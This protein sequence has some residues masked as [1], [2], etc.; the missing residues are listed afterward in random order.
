MRRS[1][2]TSLKQATLS[3][4]LLLTSYSALATESDLLAAFSALQGHIDGSATLSASQIQANK[5]IIDANRSIFGDTANA[6]SSSFN[7]VQSYESQYGPMWS[8]G[9]PTQNGYSRRDA[10]DGDIHWAMFHTM[11][12]IVDD[13][14][15]PTNIA[16]QQSLLDGYKFGSA[17]VVP[18]PVTAPTDPNQT[19]T[20]SIDASFLNTFGRNT[21]HWAEPDRNARNATGKYLAPGSIGTVTV[22][23]ELVNAGYKIRVGGQSWDFSNKNPVDRLDRSSL[24]Y[25]IDS[26]TMKIASPLGGNIYIETPFEAD[27]GVVDIEFKNVIHAPFFSMQDHN[28]TTQADWQNT[29]RNHYAPWTDL[30]TEKFMLTVPTGW[31]FA[32]DDPQS[33]LEDWDK[34]MDITNRLMGFDENR[35]KVTLYEAVDVRIRAGA[36]APGYPTVNTTYDPLRNQDASGWNTAGN[37]YNGTTGNHLLNGPH[38]TGSH[39][40]FHEIGHAYLFP[41][42][43]GETEAIVNLLHVPV[44]HEGFGYDLDTAFR[45]SRGFSD[46]YMTLD[47]TA[48]NWMTS[49]NFFYFKQPMAK[50]EKQ[51]QLKGHAKFVEV[52]RQF[53]WDA[54]GDYYRSYNEIDDQNGGRYNT[55]IDGHLLALS[56]AVGE[57]IT[58][59]FHFWGVHPE[60]TDT[61]QSD[62]EAAGVIKSRKIYDLLKHYKTLVPEDNDAFRVH[63]SQW[64]ESASRFRSSYDGTPNIDGYW[65][66]HEHARQWDATDLS[67]QEY[68][69][70]FFR[71]TDLPNGEMYTEESAAMIRSVI[72]DL[73]IEYYL[74]FMADFNGDETLDG[75]D[76]VLF[77]GNAQTDMT[78]MSYDQALLNG[79]LDGDLDNDL[80]DFILF[81]QAYEMVHTENG[82]FEAMVLEYGVPE[83]STCLL[84]LLGFSFTGNRRQRERYKTN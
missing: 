66:E 20:V 17:D 3:A 28:A 10:S 68:G 32:M 36:Y 39:V 24:V 65:T 67:D 37:A 75:N 53:G 49:F 71:S 74:D 82:A 4:T 61:L 18:G 41:K 15:N 21:M 73:M 47:T 9:S 54:I 6:I 50:L 27:A 63:A 8:A 79:D 59:L 35:G 46:P 84:L 13:T 81:R 29:E 33:V 12:Y 31:V 40:L 55:G 5:L 78:G 34:A 11:Q 26:T 77:I 42:L 25:D 30:Q 16:T 69:E 76:W 80:E 70:G 83:P 43:P 72:Q 64:W 57:D 48:I 7:L 51:Y 23:Q 1:F 52:A 22:P 56:Q 44:F 19:Y 14:Y 45:G 38:I 58:P 2:V 60:S 62:L